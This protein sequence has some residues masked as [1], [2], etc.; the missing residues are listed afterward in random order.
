[1]PFSNDTFK[2]RRE[3][4]GLGRHSMV[5]RTRERYDVI[6]VPMPLCVKISSRIA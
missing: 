4:I 2:M 1:M 5:P 3:A 6:S